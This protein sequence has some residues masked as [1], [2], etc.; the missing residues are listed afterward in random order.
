MTK[1]ERIIHNMRGPLNSVAMT[2][3]LGKLYVANGDKSERVL[4]ALETIIQQCSACAAELDAL[5]DYL[6]ELERS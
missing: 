3:E 5:Y 2:A 6:A 1:G 4:S